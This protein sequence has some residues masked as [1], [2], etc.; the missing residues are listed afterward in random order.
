MIRVSIKEKTF[1]FK[2]NKKRLKKKMPR[3]REREEASDEEQQQMAR[4]E[5][6]TSHL[7][8]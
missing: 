3:G 7:A 8:G 2:L 1:A 5:S 4:G 6:D